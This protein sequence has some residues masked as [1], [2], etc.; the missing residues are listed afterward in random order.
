MKTLQMAQDH[1][2]NA[3]RR[4][5]FTGWRG[6]AKA[7][8]KTGVGGLAAMALAGCSYG[9]SAADGADG[10]AGATARGTRDTRS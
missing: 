9:Y 10:A 1:I 3:A 6:A 4:A 5:N 2:P 7:G 8:L